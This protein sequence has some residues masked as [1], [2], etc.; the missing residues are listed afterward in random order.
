LKEAEQ[1]ENKSVVNCIFCGLHVDPE[2]AIRYQGWISHPTCAKGAITQ[3]TEN[4]DRKY[5]IIGAIGAVIG[6]VFAFLHAGAQAAFAEFIVPDY[7]FM[8][9]MVGIGLLGVSV[10]FLIHSIG[11]FGLH[12]NYVQGYAKASAIISVLVACA[13]GITAFLLLTYG[14]DPLYHNPETG[15]LLQI[16]GYWIAGSASQALFGTLSAFMGITVW[17]LEDELRGGL[18][19]PMILGI[20]LVIIGALVM[21]C[22]PMIALCFVVI[23]LI[24]TTAGIPKCWVEIEK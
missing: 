15:H 12:R 4:F 24:F 22:F 16:P 14:L 23:F 21:Y 3:R 18:V 7:I 13:F 1:T 5:F 20:L 2:V 11:L 17:L 9:L 8:T 6:L 19:P 10:G